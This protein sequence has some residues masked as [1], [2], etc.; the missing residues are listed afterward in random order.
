L[1]GTR[2][3][4]ELAQRFGRTCSSILNMRHKLGITGLKPRQKWTKAHQA[5]LGT[6]PDAELARRLGRTTRAVEDQRH[7]LGIPKL[8]NRVRRYTAA[9]DRL[10]GTMPDEELARRLGRTPGAIEVRRVAH[11]IACFG[12][13]P[14]SRVGIPRGPLWAAKDRALLG[15]LPDSEISLRLGRTMTAV[16]AQ[17]KKLGLRDPSKRK[18]WTAAEVKLLG[19]AFDVVIARRL[20]RSEGSVKTQRQKLGIPASPGKR[21]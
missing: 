1:L 16:R 3:D 9:E 11:G 14:G 20:G 13:K 19:T 6:A 2:P 17:R 15:K 10:L 21:S 8:D 7:L 5:L 4:S 12:W 18:P